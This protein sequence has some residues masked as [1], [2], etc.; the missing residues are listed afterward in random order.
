MES[1]QVTMKKLELEMDVS[2]R[3]LGSFFVDGVR[4]N[5]YRKVNDRFIDVLQENRRCKRIGLEEIESIGKIRAFSKK[6][7]LDT[8]L[9][10]NVILKA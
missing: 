9:H 3:M 1:N 7:G 8:T 10:A 2:L 4:C 5:A 6:T